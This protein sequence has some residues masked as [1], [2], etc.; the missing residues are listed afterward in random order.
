MKSS[1]PRVNR[2]TSPSFG[3]LPVFDKEQESMLKDKVLKA[4]DLYHGVTTRQCKSIA[5][6]LAEKCQLPN[7]FNSTKRL[8]GDKWLRNFMGRNENLSIRKP[9]ST[10]LQRIRGFTKEKVDIFFNNLKS[11][12]SLNKIA[13]SRIYN[14]DETGITTVHR[15]PN[16]LAKKGQNK[17]AKRLQES[18]EK[19]RLFYV[20]SVPLEYSIP[21]C[22]Y[23]QG[24]DHY[25]C[26]EGVHLKDQWLK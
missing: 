9:E 19:Q 23:L 13:P 1:T 24:K 16:I 14:L 6:N 18:E 12:Q 8:T 5:F 25:L 20:V 3:R 10:S 4:S 7:P 21:Q 11:V 2:S 15:P 22:L 17:L 26:L